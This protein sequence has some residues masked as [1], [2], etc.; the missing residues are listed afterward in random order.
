MEKVARLVDAIKPGRYQLTLEPNLNDFAFTGRETIEFE[1]TTASKQLVFHAQELDI[2]KARIENIECG[3]SYQA[4]NQTVAFSFDKELPAGSHKIELEFSG[5]LREGLEGFYRSRYEVN[6]QEKWLATTQFES[7]DA[8]RAFVCI[9]EPAAK[10]VFDVT[11]IIDR[12]LAAISNTNIVSE[13]AEGDKKRLTFAPTPKMSTYLL[14]FLVGEFEKVETKTKNGVHVGVYTTAGKKHQAKFALDVAAKTLDFYTDYFGIPYP[15]P[16]LDM[17]A[18]PDFAAGAMENW[19]AVTYRETAI[20]VDPEQSSLANKQW[21]A[22]VVAHELAHQ[23]FGNLVT[24]SW[25]TDLWLNEGFASW[26]EY[27]AVGPLFAEWQLWTPVVNDDYTHARNL[28]ALANT[29]PIEVEVNHPGE[30]AEIFD[31]ISYQKGASVIR[32]L[33]HF[34]GEEFFKIGLHNYLEK[35]SYDNAVTTDLWEALE[36]ASGIPVK[37][38]MAAWTSQPGFPLV[39]VDEGLVSQQRYFASPAHPEDSTTWPVPLKFVTSEGPSQQTLLETHDSELKI[40]LRGWF[41]PNPEQTGFY[42]VNYTPEMIKALDKP[43]KNLSVLDRFGVV[44]DVNALVRAGLLSSDQ[45]LALG[46]SLRAETNYAVWNGLIDGFGGLMNISTPD[47]ALRTKLE[48]FGLLWLEPI[49]AH[50]GWEPKPDEPH[51]DTLLRPQIISML[52]HYGHKDIIT[53]A[54]KRFTAQL[55]GQ[56]IA[57]D[58]RSAVYGIVARHGSTKDYEAFYAQYKATD[59]QEEQRRLLG[60]LGNFKDEKFNKRTLELSLSDEVRSQD[61]VGVILRVL[62]NRH[63]REQAWQFI[64][65]NWKELVKRFGEGHTIS[66][67]PQGVGSVFSRAEDATRVEKFFAKNTVPS[68]ERTVK[69]ALENIRLQADWYDRDRD[70]LNKFLDQ[71]KS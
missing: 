34:I 42:I 7:T 39:S 11:L 53:E 37:K 71:A 5:V 3:I 43:L 24:M 68:I 50:L 69:Q 9:D 13:E 51:F 59:L 17:I 40:T 8:R 14:A 67:I 63:G 54:R 26:V 47:E 18:V 21:A 60:A 4:E 57:A 30:I 6:G 12:G 64:Q 52:G 62:G 31:A 58:L 29:H 16:K 1:L 25:W 48:K 36:A 65:D 38:I 2:A 35:F 44:S 20:L 49:F 32:M 56:P 41:K 15:L 22:M 70:K 61:S 33:Y 10:A 27:L 23:W 19:G 46:K 28:D 66:Y 45:I 55:E